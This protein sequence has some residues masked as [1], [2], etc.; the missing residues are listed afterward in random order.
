ME[1]CHDEFGG[2]GLEQR[3]RERTRDEQMAQR[4]LN[5]PTLLVDHAGDLAEIATAHDLTAFT[6]QHGQ[7][8]T[9]TDFL[10]FSELMAARHGAT[11]VRQAGLPT[12]PPSLRVA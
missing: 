10:R 12:F 3:R 8:L 6:R 2:R 4:R 7:R 5:L 11:L 9:V 1:R